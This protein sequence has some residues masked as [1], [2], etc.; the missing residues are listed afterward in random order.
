MNIIYLILIFVYVYT[1]NQF[2]EYKYDLSK[3]IITSSFQ[4]QLSSNTN[5]YNYQINSSFNPELINK[6]INFGEVQT[7]F[8]Y[9]KK[10]YLFNINLS[11]YKIDNDLLIYFYPLDCQIEIDNNIKIETISN[12]EYNAYYAIIEKDKIEKTNFKIRVL[13]NL[14][15]ENSKNRTYHL[16]INSLE[17]INNAELKVKEKKP[18]I[19]NFNNSLNEIKL[20]YELNK[21]EQYPIV[22][23]FFIKERVK[24]EIKVN[25]GE[26]QEFNKI[27]YYEDKVLINKNFFPNNSLYIYISIKSLEKEK[28]AIMITKIIGNHL[29]P[30]YLQKNFLNLGFI[31]NYATYQYY[32][33]EVFKG[34][35]GEIILNNKRYNGILISKIIKKED[36]N[37]YHIIN[38]TKLFPNEK[39]KNLF[40]YN[41]TYLVYN[42]YFQKLSFISEQTNDCNN[43]CY[44]LIT[45]YS[46]D[47]N[48]K[49]K[50]TY[51]I[52]TEYT[53]LTR[54]WDEEEFKSQIVNIP[55]NEYIFGS[56]ENFDRSINAHYY[57]VFIPENTEN[58]AIEIQM[59]NYDSLDAFAKEGIIKINVIKQTSKTFYLLSSK[60]NGNIINLNYED[61]HMQSFEKKYISLAFSNNNELDN[62]STYYFRVLQSNST[63]NRT[64]YPLD[65]NKVNLCQTY[66]LNDNYSCFFLINNEYK[67]I[68]SNFILYGYGKQK[69]GYIYWSLKKEDIYNIDLDNISYKYNGTEWRN[70]LEFNKQT[71]A[72]YILVRIQ[73]FFSE[74]V[75]VTTNFYNNILSS[76]YLQIYSNQLFYLRKN[77]SRSY[78]LNFDLYERYRIFI[79]NTS[80]RGEMCFKYKCISNKYKTIISERQILSF[81]IKKETGS[82]HFYSL[83]NLVS[84]IRISPENPNN[85]LEELEIDNLYIPHRINDE[86]ENVRLFGFYL[87]DIKNAGVDFNFYFNFHDVNDT[88]IYEKK[89]IILYGYITDYET[90]KII[91]NENDLYEYYGE[92]EIIG[93][94][95]ESSSSGIIEFDKESYSNYNK[96]NNSRWEILDKYCLIIIDCREIESN[97]TVEI[98]TNSKNNSQNPMPIN[99]Y[100][101]GYFNLLNNKQQI[102]SQKY[103]FQNNDKDLSDNYTIEFSSN[104]KDI[105][106]IFNNDTIKCNNIVKIKGFQKYYI[107]INY[108]NDSEL[109]SFL[110][111]INNTNTK[112]SLKK[113]SYIFKYYNDNNGQNI[114]NIFD[115][116]SELNQVNNPNNINY[117]NLVIQNKNQNQNI[118]ITNNYN[119]TYFLKIY[120]KKDIIKDEILNTIAPINSEAYLKDIIQSKDPTEN[121]VFKLEELPYQEKYI[122]SIII[123]VENE[124][125]KDENYYYSFTFE[126]N[127]FLKSEEKEKEDRILI[128]IIVSI[129]IVFIIVLFSLFMCIRKLRKQ[130]RKLEQKVISIS[131]SS[132]FDE[133]SIDKDINPKKSED[134]ENTFI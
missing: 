90:I 74:I 91:N 12:Y 51:I 42:E 81:Y 110:V 18:F 72:E 63:N 16:V 62:D 109:N 39:E 127:T 123:K 19:L 4:N 8:L 98:L 29:S 44:L 61:L 77:K 83:N 133:D 53:L 95:D 71:S 25:N 55:L 76:P 128:I 89:N 14:L 82:I 70:Y 64:I 126:I 99:K 27:I 85:Y 75:K 114:D 129:S 1:K 38:N 20:S 46:N 103:F 120:D 108:S 23:S 9:D 60:K 79:N 86:N 45:Y 33:M 101:K 67:E 78:Y 68:S 118:N 22:V 6:I 11:T 119:F 47:L 116:K 106:L 100:I 30:N 73:S 50:N 24:F 36:L 113:A 21:S 48:S 2:G 15:D 37:E 32:Y 122:A 115:L 58:I 34:E 52:G 49:N 54:I 94:Y 80:G 65:T 93:L 26:D 28:N 112:T 56:F 3:N 17:Y 134:Y 88:I 130:N 84:N 5:N 57:S 125:Q 102:Q 104:Y 41:N 59:N 66:K 121:I 35:E 31:P 124:E 13:N 7:E 92:I 40:L 43:G 132:G 107:T 69:I 111:Q 10:M 87:K 96:Y 105:E 131:F 97:I 117:Y